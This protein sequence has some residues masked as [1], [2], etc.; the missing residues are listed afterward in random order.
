MVDCPRE[1]SPVERR[2]TM[3]EVYFNEQPLEAEP[4]LTLFECADR[5]AIRVPSSCGRHGSCHECIVEIT[6][7]G[8]SLSPR[9]ENEQFLR[10]PYRLSCQC[11]LTEASREV[12]LHALRRGTPQIST[13][14]K[15]VEYGHDPAV[16]RG[17]GGTVLID[18][19]PAGV[20]RGP[21]LGVAADL[22]TTTVVLRLVDLESGRMLA[23]ESFEN[24]QMFG[25][26]D[27]MGRITYDRENP[28][29]D[30]QKVL[31]A[32]INRAIDEMTSAIDAK[33]GDIYEFVAAGNATMRDLFFG[34]DVASIGERPYQ[35][36][37]EREWRAGL[38]AS[39]ALVER[40]TRL[41]LHMNRKGRVWGA[42]LVSCHVG[43]DTAACLA[44]IGMDREE[45]TV[46]MLD[47]GT[48][49]EVVLG[50]RHRTLCASCPAGPAFE[51]GGVAC[52]MP[53]LEG[54]IENVQLEDSSGFRVPSPK[55]NSDSE[56]GTGNSK[57]GTRNSELARGVRYQTIG[58]G[59]PLGICGSGLIDTLG[60]LLRSGGI[61]LLGRLAD[62]SGRFWID[63][64]RDIYLAERDISELAQAK[65]ANIAGQLILLEQYGITP[66][67]VDR[68]YLAGGF[69]Q[70]LTP[71][72]AIRIG[73]IPD[74]PLEKIEK[75]GN[76]AIEGATMMLCSASLRARIESF[77]RGMEHV[78]LEQ[79][80]NF[81]GIFVEGCQF[82]PSS[83]MMKVETGG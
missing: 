77:V 47:I 29:R 56:T 76:A 42:P 80:P 55:L 24:P 43:A 17:A 10:G 7:G 70:Y 60:E 73:M 71:E 13:S 22:G 21:L 26:T 75:I 32:Y 68:F 78:E 23:G 8:E 79:H 52:G 64:A 36:L 49:T 2:E 33:R 30:L 65:A 11:K 58:G 61:N 18:G 4:G 34:I 37:V 6:D 66:G 9:T 51:G 14:G 57:L 48:N 69:A 44:A 5:L 25:G 62:G 83:A 50:N 1:D 12:R 63:R 45:R 19:Q 59:A 16:T 35:S 3:V 39:T 54:A 72:H 82:K 28:G 67:E 46:M 20:A 41:K 27:V 74:L 40:P 81:F 53:G 38:R 15:R 31:V